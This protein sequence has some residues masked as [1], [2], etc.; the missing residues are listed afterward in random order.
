MKWR[1]ALRA[2]AGACRIMVCLVTSTLRLNGGPNAA[3]VLALT[4]PP[5]RL[6]LGPHL[7]PEATWP[8]GTQIHAVFAVWR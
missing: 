8:A 3:T 7:Q 4:P 6:T 1:E 5:R 2:A